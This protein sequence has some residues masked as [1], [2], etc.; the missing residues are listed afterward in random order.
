MFRVSYGY[1]SA[2][3][4]KRKASKGFLYSLGGFC[5]WG[6]DRMAEERVLIRG[7]GSCPLG[8]NLLLL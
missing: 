3:G 7:S 6:G 5:V 4:D 8:L 2:E 1:V